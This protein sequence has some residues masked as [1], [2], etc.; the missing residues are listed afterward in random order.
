MG[1]G[2]SVADRPKEE[3]LSRQTSKTTAVELFD[4]SNVIADAQELETPTDTVI[5]WEWKASGANRD[6]SIEGDSEKFKEEEKRLQQ[7][8]TKNM[9]ARAAGE[10]LE[11]II[12]LEDFED[13]EFHSALKVKPAILVEADEAS[14]CATPRI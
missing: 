6:R 11:P 2:S 12:E 5:E 7:I 1:C 3:A 9:T 14:T 13:G 4:P 8:R 10:P